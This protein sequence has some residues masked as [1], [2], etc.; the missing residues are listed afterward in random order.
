MLPSKPTTMRPL[1][2]AYSDKSSGPPPEEGVGALLELAERMPERRVELLTQAATAQPGSPLTVRPLARALAAADPDAAAGAWQQ[3]A[4]TAAGPSAA[5]AALMA[6][7]A[8]R[9]RPDET[10]E[11][12]E[13]ALDI[14]SGFTRV[15]WAAEWLAPRGEKATRIFT[16]LAEEADSPAE[17]KRFAVKAALADGSSLALQRALDECPDDPALQELAVGAPELDPIARATLLETLAA[18]ADGPTRRRL[19]G[20]AALP[21]RRPRMPARRRHSCAVCSTN[22]RDPHSGGGTRSNRAIQRSGR[23]R[24]VAKVRCRKG[25]GGRRRRRGQGPGT[26]GAS[27]SRSLRSERPHCGN[28][29]VANRCSMWFRP[30]FRRCVHS[31]AI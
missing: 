19:L 8:T 12:L 23:P 27:Q 10:L 25:C 13:L 2:T 22:R 30:I 29:H 9:Q 16:R 14:Q 20:S 17:R 11:S 24:I 31:S 4:E 21:T 6:A 26:R 28:S 5:H 15:G 3:Q 1:P 18:D 7:F